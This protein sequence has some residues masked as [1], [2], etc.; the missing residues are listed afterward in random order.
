[1]GKCKKKIK[2]MIPIKLKEKGGDYWEGDFKGWTNIPF[3]Y[4]SD[5][6]FTF[7]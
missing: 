6:I 7:Q 2:E 5:Y 3:L 1:M 4:V